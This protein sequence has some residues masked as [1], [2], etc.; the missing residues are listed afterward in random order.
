[1]VQEV[2]GRAEVVTRC[3]NAGG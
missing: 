2:A 1:V 3:G